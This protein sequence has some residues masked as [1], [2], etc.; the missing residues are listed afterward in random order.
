MKNC[1]K[2]ISMVLL[3]F[4]CLPI[5]IAAQEELAKPAEYKGEFAPAEMMVRGPEKE[6]REDL[7]LNGRWDFQ[8]I[9]GPCNM[10]KSPAFGFEVPDLAPDLPRADPDRWEALPMR[11][12]SSW[13]QG[14]FFPSHPEKWEEAQMGWLRK[15]FDVPAGWDG[16]RFILH[17]AAV[18]GDCK[19]EVNGHYVGG[20][21][22]SSI[23]FEF[24]V[25][26]VIKVGEPNEVQVGIRSSNLFKVE[27]EFGKQ[28]F[29]RGATKRFLG[30]WQD[31][32]LLALPPVYIADVFVQ[33]DVEAGMLRAE[34]R[35]HNATGKPQKIQLGATV[36]DWV[37]LAAE[38]AAASP[39]IAWELGRERL[40][41]SPVKV[42]IPA[43]G[44]ELVVLEAKVEGQLE[45]WDIHQ[46][47]L[48][49]FTTL[50]DQKG[51]AVDR[52][53]ERFGWREF[54]IQGDRFLVNGRPVQMLGD[55]QHLNNVS[56]L[57]RRFAWS[58]YTLLREAGGNAARLHAVVFPPHF[59]EMADEMGILILPESS[60][61]GSTCDV[62]YESELFK[63]T[64]WHNVEGM[65]RE[66]RN[67]ACVFGWSVENEVLPALNVQSS[68]TAYK[69]RVHDFMGELGTLCTQ[70]DPTRNWISGDGSGDMDGR[71]PVYLVHYGSTTS[72]R[73]DAAATDK[74]FGVGEA[75]IAYYSTPRQSEMY[76]GDR[77]YRSYMDHQDAI[78]IDAYELLTV[79]REV[80]IFC[81]IWNLGYYGVKKLP[82]GG[83]EGIRLM[84]PFKEGKPG[85]QVGFLPSRSTQYN[86]GYDPELPLYQPLPLFHAV[87]AAYHQP[88]PL[89]CEWDRRQLFENPPPP[90]HE[91]PVR[92]IL[93]FG[94]QDS[95]AYFKLKNAGLPL[96]DEVNDPA[97]VL[98][99]AQLPDLA[100]KGLPA[101]E[102][103]I[104]EHATVLFW[105]LTP[106]NVE[107][108]NALLP[109]PVELVERKATALMKNT[110]DEQVASIPYKDL[111]FSQNADD[112]TI[113]RYG[114][115]GPLV[116]HGTVLLMAS[117]VDWSR[118]D[119][120]EKP[121]DPA[122]VELK[123]DK[124]TYMVSTLNM[125]ILT[126]AHVRM[127]G[128]LFTNLG[129]ELSPVEFKRGSVFNQTSQLTKALVVDCFQ[130]SSFDE[131][132]KKD[133]LGGAPTL[134]AELDMSTEGCPWELLSSNSGHFDLKRS[135]TV[136]EAGA[137]RVAYMSFWLYSPKP[138]NEIM[139]DPHV[140]KV[141]F[142]LSSSAGNRLWL[143]GKLLHESTEA[144]DGALVEKLPLVKGWN[145]FMVKVLS[146]DDDWH[147]KGQLL[148]TDMP[149]LA[150]MRSALNPH[151]EKANFSVIKHTDSEI[152]YDQ[153]WGLQGDGWYESATPG[154]KATFTFYGSGI[155]MT[156]L[157]F[158][159]GGKAKLYIDGKLE[160]VIDY[161]REQRDPHGVIFSKSGLHNGEHEVVL[162]VV[163]GWVALG[164][165]EQWESY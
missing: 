14:D 107:Q 24:D 88:E 16:K 42:K 95:D 108:V 11:I 136:T 26:D 84:A 28:P 46:P 106:Q 110:E 71:F 130:A 98:V 138:L 47:N 137:Q 125:D 152:V 165:Y 121:R 114:M 61:Y 30:I 157:V 58:W 70:L 74:P 113:M 116:D 20:N 140:P 22:D 83:G 149:L 65:V 4:A 36:Q 38:D 49:G 93:Y 111:Y 44:E 153:Y 15:S 9:Y 97:F 159:K 123:S 133:F 32:H 68:D 145:H 78:A 73:E 57:S 163:E 69:K 72:Y 1:L 33:P 115:K 60:I 132:F 29:P 148:S 3:H 120:N 128:Q 12:P 91:S 17:F 119:M 100:S 34:V 158:P 6:V 43:H 8:P 62:N 90:E 118:K 51:E 18:S 135:A 99:D 64:A 105:G 25:T 39:E 112:K 144:L 134:Q 76:V 40:Q 66:Y 155:E 151:A 79:Q 92:E 31:V 162:E 164:P 94:S 146:S 103:A 54:R 96:S 127:L 50:L 67:H 87:K 156:G 150:S 52:K 81:S 35:V 23:P 85:M 5:G 122:L 143:N 142:Q 161:Y 55:S 86:P 21:F 129:V 77:A 89:P 124:G 48:Y 53:Y 7:C 13:N 56:H 141:H 131:A 160:T 102:E 59:C 147:F 37:N 19:V 27:T 75:C 154:A 117:P 80:G 101:V 126:P 10:E 109:Q 104:D 82:L 63:K 45:F 139:A 41:F 2:K